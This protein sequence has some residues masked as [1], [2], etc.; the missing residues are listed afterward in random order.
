MLRLKHFTKVVQ[1][2]KSH[3]FSKLLTKI[4]LKTE[5]RFV[6]NFVETFYFFYYSI[7]SFIFGL[8]HPVLTIVYKFVTN[9]FTKTIKFILE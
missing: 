3:H 4:L 1:L 8:K 5:V 6:N 2:L 9:K 7:M